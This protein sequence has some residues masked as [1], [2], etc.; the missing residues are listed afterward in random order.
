MGHIAVMRSEAREKRALTDITNAKI[1]ATVRTL[2]TPFRDI[3]QTSSDRPKRVQVHIV[4][5]WDARR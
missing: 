1:D 2:K 3:T 5:I 4:E